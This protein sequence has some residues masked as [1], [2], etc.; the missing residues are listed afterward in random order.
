MTI[1]L[2][3]I[4]EHLE[5]LGPAHRLRADELK[6]LLPALIDQYLQLRDRP[7]VRKTHH[8]GGRYENIYVGRELI[9][10]LDAILDAATAAA[11]VVA[12]ESRP[13]RAGY[14]FNE[15]QPGQETT[16]HSHDDDDE[17]L[18]GVFYVT[19]PEDSGDLLLGKG[20]EQVAVAPIESAFV[21][22]P[23][24]LPHAVG[25]NLSDRMR[26]SIGMNFG[27]SDQEH[28]S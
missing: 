21:F 26:L 28:Q 22:F 7:E 14:W 15:M 20:D 4:S 18:S 16:L 23:P 5:L 19:V 9:P 10:E 8:F 13:L 3:S 1:E 24:S 11:A 25:R 17:I 27:V 6:P 12:G 2:D